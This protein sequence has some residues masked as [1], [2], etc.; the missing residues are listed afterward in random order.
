MRHKLQLEASVQV[1]MY[2][3]QEDEVLQ[4]ERDLVMREV[5]F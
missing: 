4:K 5:S 3:S 2:T 1:V